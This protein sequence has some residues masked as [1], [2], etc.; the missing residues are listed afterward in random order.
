M[1]G[2]PRSA[3]DQLVEASGGHGFAQ[4][5]NAVTDLSDGSWAEGGDVAVDGTGDVLSMFW[6]SL[7]STTLP[8][9]YSVDTRYRP[10]ANGKQLAP[11]RVRS[12]G[13]S[14]AG[15]SGQSSFM[16]SGNARSL[17]NGLIDS[18]SRSPEYLVGMRRSAVAWHKRIAPIF[19]KRALSDNGWTFRRY[20]GLGLFF[21]TEYPAPLPESSKQV[22]FVR[23]RPDF[24]LRRAVARIRSK[25][26]GASAIS[27][28]RGS[29]TTRLTGRRYGRLEPV[30]DRPHVSNALRSRY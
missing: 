21:G 15:G 22:T 17:G 16:L 26:R 2:L 28:R 27:C 5:P 8:S 20:D 30:I 19:G 14:S 29:G 13:G 23:R 4:P 11:S 6:Q 7:T 3:R 1:R 24:R 18:G 25:S 9:D 10:L 12:G